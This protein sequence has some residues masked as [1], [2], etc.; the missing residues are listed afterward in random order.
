MSGLRIAVLGLLGQMTW[1]N[2]IS[3]IEGLAEGDHFRYGS[4]RFRWNR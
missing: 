4:H 1:A 3:P 2:P